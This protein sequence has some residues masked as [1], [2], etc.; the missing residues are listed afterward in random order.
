QHGVV[1]D[2]RIEGGDQ[3]LERRMPADGVVEG[4]AFDRALDRD[5]LRLRGR[6]APIL[7]RSPGPD[8]CGI[9]P[10]RRDCAEGGG[11]AHALVLNATYEPLCVVSS[12]RAVVLVLAGKATAV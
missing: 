7:A 3:P 11:V 6:H 5:R 9:G 12:R 4:R 8:A 2:P 10:D 1:L